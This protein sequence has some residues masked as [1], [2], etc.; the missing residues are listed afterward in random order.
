MAK[1]NGFKIK[2]FCGN[3]VSLNSDKFAK[4]QLVINKINF[5]NCNFDSVSLSPIKDMFAFFKIFR[6]LKNYRPD[7]VHITTPKAQILGGIASRILK[8]RAIVIFIS[9]MGYLF[10]ND[11]N[12]IEKIYKKLLF[13]IQSF[14]FKHK[15][16]KIIVENKYDYKYF[17]NSFS[18]KK[19]QI[20]IVRGSG[21]D[22]KKFKKINTNQNKI[23]LLPA[24]VVRE[25]GIIEF[26]KASRLL[27]QYKYKFVVAGSLD[28]AKSSGLKKEELEEANIDKTVKFIGYQKNI[29]KI[30]K[31]TAIVCL[32]SYR[33]G[34]PK[35]LCE[36][37]AC[38]IPIVTTKSVGCT[39]VVKSKF[40]GEL[41]RIKDYLSLATKIK[42]LILEP[43]L[44]I[45]YGKN[46]INF[47]KKNFD[48]KLIGNKIID[49][50]NELLIYEK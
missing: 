6:E 16:L 31:K 43:K 17:V 3:S 48:I 40:N 4:Q 45:I 34:L 35:S 8:V 28:Y 19:N 30:L 7:I 23:I 18:L 47:A 44:R 27:K 14:L 24:R 15:K 29:Y 1:K 32:P 36:A 41:C 46:S 39:E 33:E 20:S 25:K 37:A 2:V 10:S 21:V 49:I 9:G 5:V 38:G 50:Y 13:I 42:K 12:F 22:L 26:I 11:L